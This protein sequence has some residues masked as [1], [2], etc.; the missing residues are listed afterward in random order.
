MKSFDIDDAI[1]KLDQISTKR[2][3]I[4]FDHKIK[5]LQDLIYYFPRKHL[6]RT[7]IT[8]ICDVSRGEKYNIIG[9]VERIGEIS[10]RY[11]KIFHAIISDGTG[12]ITLKWFNSANY[13]K[14]L[15][16]KGDT[17]AIHGKVEWY[18][19][20]TINHP[21]FDRL[22]YNENPV[23]TGSIISIYPLT[24][25]LK[26]AGIEQRLIRKILLQA[27]NSIKQYNDMFDEFFIKSNNLYS[28]NDSLKQIHFPK[29][30]NNLQKAIYRLKF[31]EHFILQI[32]MALVKRNIKRVKTKSLKDI[33]PYFRTIQGSLKFVLTK[34][35]KRVMKEIHSDMKKNIC[36]NRLLQG[37]VGSG[38]TIVS[39]LSTVLAVGNNVQVAIMAPTE[40]LASQHY[41]S[42]QK[43]LSKVKI[44][45]CL[46]VGKLN[47][48]ERTKIIDNL[49]D[50]VISVVIGTHAIIQDDVRFK[51]L[52]LVIIDEQHRFGVS[53]RN[54]LIN[55]GKN[56]HLLSM[57]AT[58]IPRTLSI[59]YMGD[60]DLSIIDELPKNRIPITTKVVGTERLSKVYSFIKK[61]IGLGQQ[62]MIVYPL[63]EE[64]EKSDIAAAVNM[65][66]KLKK[67]IFKDNTIGLIH[68]K[69][70]S[71]EKKII[72][73]NYEQ[74]NIKILVATTVIEVG[75]DV[76]NATII[77]IEHAEKFGLTQLHQLRG[78]VG[79]GSEKS[80]CI[81]VNRGSHE[82]SSNRLDIM[83]K[84]NDGFRIADEDLKLRGPGDYIGYQQS[85]FIKYKMADIITDGPII[86]K[87]RDLAKITVDKDPL[88]EKNILI[89]KRLLRDYKEKLK[90]IKLN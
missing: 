44:T 45:C 29:N 79:R 48:K 72:M 38:K 7:N 63:V 86:R 33:G 56:P 89:K 54:K 2:A 60:M 39:I 30:I 76:P 46:L 59:T 8:L 66:K 75:V 19:G 5:S 49:E 55:K 47:K 6:D 70:E 52:G 12:L 16:K 87:A 82:K 4:L 1:T 78:R 3:K 42:F 62:C 85:G 43:E 64:S 14:K 83:E 61:Q 40:I 17:V 15:F 23:N 22:D 74:N 57:T 41:D 73:K 25:E 53:Q 37:D 24:S 35:Q 51:N 84:T 67:N 11:K 50:G 68:G 36:M 10:T 65:Y 88:L 34:A 69:M 31:D 9:K 80:Y 58:P 20:F 21:E 28:L 32:F 18:K 77:L 90:L 27:L 81:L 26:S 71:D 13:I